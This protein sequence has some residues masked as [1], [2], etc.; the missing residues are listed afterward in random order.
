MP[1][2]LFPL[3][4]ARRSAALAI[5]L[6]ASAPHLLS[7]RHLGLLHYCGEG[8]DSSIPAAAVLVLATTAL[9]ALPLVKLH[10]VK[11]DAFVLNG[12]DEPTARLVRMLPYADRRRLSF[13][14]TY[15]ELSESEWVAVC[16]ETFNA[17]AD[18]G[19]DRS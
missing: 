11:A 13:A 1:P 6:A 18:Y 2:T 3:P 12:G 9:P 7:L 16:E 8:L 15:D 19:K 14:T 5:E 4:A 17:A 10:I